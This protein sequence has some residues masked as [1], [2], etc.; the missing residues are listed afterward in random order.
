MT[1]Y[2]DLYLDQG[3]DFEKNIRLLDESTG[4]SINIAGYSFTSKIRKG[5]LT[6]NTAGVFTTS[7]VNA[8]NGTFRISINSANTSNI[9][10]GR[11]VYDIIQTNT[12]NTKTKIYDGIVIV[13]PGVS[14]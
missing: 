11:Y 4:N 8:S 12:S 9:E 6:T 2:L 7:I 14:R 10:F 5:P 13:S 1:K 3:A